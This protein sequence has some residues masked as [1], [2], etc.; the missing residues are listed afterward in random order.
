MGAAAIA[1]STIVTLGLLTPGTAVADT[2]A[3]DPLEAVVASTPSTANNAADV[4]TKSTGKNAISA[5]VSGAD[6]SVP[7]DPAARIS[8][9]TN[10]GRLSV[11]LPFVQKAQN[12]TVEK[13]GIVS[14]NNSNGSTSVPVVTKDGSLQINTV[15]S[16][17]SAPKQYSYEFTIPDGGQI[18]QAGDGYFVLNSTNDPIAYIAAPWAK[19]A[20]KNSV[21]THYELTGTTLTQVID[22]TNKTAFPVV[23]DPQF[24]WYGVLPSVQFT[25]SETKTA[26]ALTGMATACGWVTRFTS[27]VGG[28]LCGLNAASIIINTQRIYYREKRCAQ[29]LIGPGVIGT[30]GYSGGYCK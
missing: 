13:N 14:Y 1:A 10:A 24:V 4:T 2:G 3:P 5:T 9:D 19:D 6:I 26:T 28:A 23:A 18:V 8:L 29:L 20:N 11:A 25:R 16:T 27:Y 17:V 15:I 22:L 7:V 21:P 12:A 30:I